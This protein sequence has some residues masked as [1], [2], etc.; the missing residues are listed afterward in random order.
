MGTRPG[1]G[2]V[3]GIRDRHRPSRKGSDAASNRHRARRCLTGGSAGGSGRYGGAI[4]GGDTG[5]IQGRYR[6]GI[7]PSTLV[8]VRYSVS[9][10]R[11]ESCG[12]APSS[13]VLPPRAGG[14][15]PWRW[16]VGACPRFESVSRMKVAVVEQRRSAFSSHARGSRLK[17]GFAIPHRQRSFVLPR[18][19][20]ASDCIGER[21]RN[22]R[23]ERDPEIRSISSDIV[24]SIDGVLGSFLS[25]GS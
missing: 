9:R 8:P 13:S 21:V 1:G 23:C 16:T 11:G 24:V 17:P 15:G 22:E 18:R 14:S 6:T 20:R 3:G 5:A 7:S 25:R 4:R 19:A 2:G 12:Q 10:A